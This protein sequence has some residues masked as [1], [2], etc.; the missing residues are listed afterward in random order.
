MDLVLS[1][2]KVIAHAIQRI[3]DGEEKLT[4]PR[5]VDE[6][7]ALNKWHKATQHAL[8]ISTLADLLL[9]KKT[10]VLA[11]EQSSPQRT[12][13]TGPDSGDSS[14]P[15]ASSSEFVTT[16]SK[17]AL[18]FDLLRSFKDGAF[19]PQPQQF[20]DAHGSISYRNV[21]NFLKCAH[22]HRNGEHLPDS[23]ADVMTQRIMSVFSP[24]LQRKKVSKK[25]QRRKA[26]AR[27]KSARVRA[28]TKVTC[29]AFRTALFLSSYGT[30]RV[31]LI[32]R[33][34]QAESKAA[35][36]EGKKTMVVGGGVVY[37]PKTGSWITEPTK[38][39]TV[40][41]DD[42]NTVPPKGAVQAKQA[43]SKGPKRNFDSEEADLLRKIAEAKASTAR[44]GDDNEKLAQAAQRI[45]D[46]EAEL[47]HV[48]Q[49][50]EQLRSFLVPTAS[51]L[52]VCS[53]FAAYSDSATASCAHRMAVLQARDESVITLKFFSTV[54]SSLSQAVQE[55]S[56]QICSSAA[57]PFASVCNYV[58]YR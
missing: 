29:S 52:Q 36:I 12:P 4:L 57:L 16:D 24:S 38:L 41:D 34:L 18:A 1:R 56:S 53:I 31:Q 39:V 32:V 19:Q 43:D 26:K 48:V 17:I 55:A 27:A 49:A 22:M 15:S 2:H 40:D 44:D 47:Q 30:V 23:Q 58:P 42:D 13:T 51:A 46:L 5:T 9:E 37:D 45:R 3:A 25:I 6:V 28:R 20:R 50:K 33:L 35:A 8:V 7:Q 54:L 10:K 14:V 11:W 21:L